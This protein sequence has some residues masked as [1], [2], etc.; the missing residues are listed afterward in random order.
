MPPLASTRE[1][2]GAPKIV[3]LRPVEMVTLRRGRD[4]SYAGCATYWDP[5]PGIREQM[6]AIARRAG[7]RLREEVDFRGTFTV[8]GV[9]T[10][11]G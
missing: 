9:V 5:D 4:F 8:D 6:R 1:P 2:S 11:D 10:S 7:D 3:V